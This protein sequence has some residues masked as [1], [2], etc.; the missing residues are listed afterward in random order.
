MSFSTVT[1]MEAKDRRRFGRTGIG[2]CRL[3]ARR[4]KFRRAV[5]LG[6]TEA[7]QLMAA[8]AEGA[9]NAAFVVTIVT[10]GMMK[11]CC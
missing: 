4:G 3:L 6:S 5:A 11:W 1:A 2:R 10:K 8:T 7:W 9:P